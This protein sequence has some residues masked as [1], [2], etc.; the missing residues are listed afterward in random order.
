MRYVWTS[1][2]LGGGAEPSADT[3]SNRHA[4]D[5]RGVGNV[6]EERIGEGAAEERVIRRETR[7]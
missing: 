4:G 6:I 1:A 7:L 5:M 2:S 3:P